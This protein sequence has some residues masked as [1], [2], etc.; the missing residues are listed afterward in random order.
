MIAGEWRLRLTKLE[1]RVLLKREPSTM[2]VV[3][4]LDQPV[5]CKLKVIV[6]YNVTE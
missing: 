5:S 4:S 2:V 6:Q 3:T 1:V